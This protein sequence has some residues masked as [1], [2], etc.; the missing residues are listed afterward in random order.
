MDARS[1]FTLAPYGAIVR[2]SDGTPKPPERFK[3]KLREWNS[4]N[5]TGRFVR[6]E[7]TGYSGRSRAYLHCRARQ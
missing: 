3:N 2:F 7:T 5:S 6:K 4:N 1:L